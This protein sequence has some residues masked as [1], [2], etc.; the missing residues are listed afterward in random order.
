MNIEIHQP[1]IEAL[2]QQRMATGAFQDVEAVIL[3]ALKSSPSPAKD[4]VQ[5]DSPRRA[6]SGRT[7]TDLIAAMKK[8]PYKDTDFEPSRPHLPV[9]E[10]TL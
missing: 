10:V 7:G 5:N 1:E 8:M 3:H 9:R 4:A 6:L 2:I